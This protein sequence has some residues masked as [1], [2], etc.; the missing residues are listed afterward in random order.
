MRIAHIVNPFRAPAGSEPAMYQPVTLESIRIAKEF[1][2]AAMQIELYAVCFEEDKE[3]VPSYFTL[4]PFLNR[5][6]LDLKKFSRQK[7]FPFIA[8]VLH[9]LHSASSAEYLM[10]TN[11]DIALLPQFYLAIN[12]LLRDN[13]DAVVVNRRC[14]SKKHASLKQLPLMYSD[15]GK[16]HPGFDCFIFKRELLPKMHLGNICLGV[17]FSEVA[18]LHN[19]IAY[20]S[21]L[22]LIDDLHLTFHIGTEVMPPLD[23]EYYTHNRE[24]YEKNI[25]PKISS[26]LS[27]D[28]FPYGQLSFPKR[29]L[30][31]ML[32]PSFRTHQMLAYEG[33]SGWRAIKYRLDAVRFKLM[34][35]IR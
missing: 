32:N 13:C 21:R 23:K 3:A 5:S 20:S 25:Y 33:I 34:D 14:I 24:E 4:L 35:S 26:L 27:I 19:L 7:K 10:F 30:K 18:V 22:K 2:G 17:S 1:A 28:K 12:E 16:P 29:M 9:A 31:W 11:M 8:D 15:Y 6:V